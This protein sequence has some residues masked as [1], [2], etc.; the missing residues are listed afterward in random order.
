[1]DLLSRPA[2]LLGLFLFDFWG[3]L[4]GRVPLYVKHT[5]TDPRDQDACILEWAELSMHTGV[6]GA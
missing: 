4:E 6:G 3:S 1:M 2:R 5:A